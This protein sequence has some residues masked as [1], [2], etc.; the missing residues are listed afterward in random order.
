MHARSLVALPSSL[1]LAAFALIAGAGCG[2]T[3]D[4]TNLC[5]RTL[6]CE[7]SFQP[8]DDPTEAKVESGE[9]TQLESCALGCQESPLVT[10]ESATCVDG[11]DV[12]DASVCQEQVLQCLGV[13]ESAL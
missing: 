12:R 8:T 1:V 7:V 2:P 5:Q 3:I 6:A 10:V 9:R 13:D 4:C 11:L